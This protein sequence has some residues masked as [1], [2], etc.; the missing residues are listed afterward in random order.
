MV[1]HVGDSSA[2]G[3]VWFVHGVLGQGRNWRSFARR[4]IEGLNLRAVLPDLRNHGAHPARTGPHTLRAA[5]E[6]L[7]ELSATSGT[8]DV[9]VGHSLG[10][11]VA[12]EWL[13]TGL[14]PDHVSVWVLDAPPGIDVMPTQV[15]PADVLQNL[16]EAPV[17]AESREPVR[18]FLRERGLPEG[19]VMWLLTSAERRGAHWDWVYDLD[20]V[21]AML[22]DYWARSRWD[23]AEDPRVN[24]VQ[25][26]DGG[27][28]SDREL[29][30]ATQSAASFHVL[31]NAGHW[32]HVDN[33]EGTL[34]LLRPSLRASQR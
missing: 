7:Q 13:G 2:L 14:L 11:K 31:P 28:W 17:P 4:A 12:L 18:A 1:H 34:G 23:L 33:P 24:L 20:G 30:Q 6:D 10:G 27:R 26:A 21:Q 8:P 29:E 5:A 25:A 32:L 22:D 19:I 15:D 3:T 9:V 16:R